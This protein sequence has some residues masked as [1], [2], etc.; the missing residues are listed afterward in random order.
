SD[1]V[2]QTVNT[3]VG[4]LIAGI[5]GLIVTKI[6]IRSREKQ[7]EKENIRKFHKIYYVLKP[8][9]DRILSLLNDFNDDELQKSY[10]IDLPKTSLINHMYAYLGRENDN[11]HGA[12]KDSV[13]LSYF[14]LK[15]IIENR[16]DLQSIYETIFSLKDEYIP[17]EFYSIYQDIL[18]NLKNIIQF[19]DKF[20]YH[21]E[22][23]PKSEFQSMLNSYDAHSNNK[24]IQS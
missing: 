11:K 21:D 6:D 2:I 15:Q 8:L 12:R 5:I 23:I 16:N 17:H 7:T 19:A 10:P 14:H 1:A 22:D 13:E 9:L 4:A 18:A 20:L 3:I 24:V